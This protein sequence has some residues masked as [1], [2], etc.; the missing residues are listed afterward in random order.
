M[1]TEI[2]WQQRFQNF[3]KA[4][5]SLQQSIEALQKDPANLFIR[6]SV[7]QRYEYSIEL[8]WKT[9]KDY[10][11]HEGFIN[12][13]SPK[14][15]IRQSLQQGYISD[16]QWLKALDDR[17]KTTHAYDENMANEVTKEITEQY[18]F[19]LKDLYSTLEKELGHE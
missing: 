15:V 8:A 18:F 6:D 17:N 12:V 5:L 19:L 2:R 1:Y 3:A 9:L 16:A 7:I 13:S 14:R 11:E 4:Y 10:L